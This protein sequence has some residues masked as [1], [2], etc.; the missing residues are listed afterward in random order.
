MK[1]LFIAT[2][3]CLI[4]LQAFMPCFA[5]EELSKGSNG[6]AVVEL[7]NRLNELG[8]SVGTADGDFGG[9][10]KAAVE[11][12]QSENGLAVTGIV[13]SD[14]YNALFST[15]VN[16]EL[17]ESDISKKSHETNK[18]LDQNETDEKTTES[19]KNQL[20]KENIVEFW[21]PVTANKL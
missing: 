4:C 15:P 17:E 8:Y 5:F 16:S 11:Q 6:D 13:D 2:L 20:I 10:T 14:T 18:G 3:V 9:K 21:Q 1:K 19:V 7:Q 12:F